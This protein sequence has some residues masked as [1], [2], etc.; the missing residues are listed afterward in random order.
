MSNPGKS[1][2][3]IAQT[4]SICAFFAGR[5]MM[6]MKVSCAPNQSGA[7]FVPGPRDVRLTA[8]V[9]MG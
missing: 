5:I 4:T 1:L 9:S 2:N 6:A 7:D 8:W 3:F